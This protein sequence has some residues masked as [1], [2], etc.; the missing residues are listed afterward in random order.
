MIMNYFKVSVI[1]PEIIAFE[2]DGFDII[3]PQDPQ[4]TVDVACE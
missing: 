1:S 4:V 3:F 2:P